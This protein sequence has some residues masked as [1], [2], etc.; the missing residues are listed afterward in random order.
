MTVNF[1]E[2]NVTLGNRKELQESF[3]PHFEEL[4]TVYT[5]LHALEDVA[6]AAVEED[7]ETLVTLEQNLSE[8]EES[9][10]G[11]TDLTIGKQFLT[12]KEDTL[13][14]IELHRAIMK[15]RNNTVDK[16]MTAKVFEFYA[17]MKNV[18]THWDS[19]RKEIVLTASVRTHKEDSAAIAAV[20]YKLSRLMSGIKIILTDAGIIKQGVHSLIDGDKKV[21]LDTTV[22]IADAER[23]VLDALQVGS[24]EIN[25]VIR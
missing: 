5:E 23:N 11:V 25:R 22:R 3:T 21:Y 2:L 19:F 8:I 12:L 16:E 24:E 7:K 9:L 15:G 13:K 17:V 6:E 20:N 4:Q 1:E 10:T 18:S 14:D